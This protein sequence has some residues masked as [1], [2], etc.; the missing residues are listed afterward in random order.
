MKW[1]KHDSNANTDAKLKKVR[2]K[3]GMSGYGLYWYCLEL[4]CSDIEKTNITFELEHDSEIIAF[5][6]GINSDIVNE[7]MA[8]MIDLELFESIE[9]T[10]TCMKMAKR[11]DQSMTSNPEMRLLIDKIRHSHDSVMIKSD[12]VMQDKTRLDKKRDINKPSPKK[13]NGIPYQKIVDL[14][15]QSLPTLPK[16][17]KL[18]ETRKSQIRQRLVQKDLEDLDEWGNY[19]DYVSQSKF[20]MGLSPANNG[21]K[22]FIANLEWLTKESNFVK[23]TEGNYHG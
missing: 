12:K 23:I 3:Y 19:F 17:E 20:L 11:L 13:A 6:T 9:G 8:F 22:P 14:Y 15:H 21:R 5:D 18:T 1:F 10:I 4:I 2:M 16:V 7:M